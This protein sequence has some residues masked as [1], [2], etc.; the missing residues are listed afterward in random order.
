MD[1]NIPTAAAFCTGFGQHDTHKDTGEPY[2]KVTFSDIVAM[3]ENPPQTP[4][5]QAQWTIASRYCGWDARVFEVQRD[6]GEFG[7]IGLDFDGTAEQ[8]ANSAKEIGAALRAV[9]GEDATR[10][11]YSS[12]RATEAN[13]KSRVLLPLAD[14]IPGRDWSDT[15]EAIHQLLEEHGL[16]PDPALERAAQL[17]FLPNRG[18]YYRHSLKGV[19]PVDLTPDHPVIQRRE[20][21]RAARLEAERAAQEE[22]VWKAA[23]R[24]ARFHET[25]LE[26]PVDHFNK[27]HS[28]EGLLGRY[29]YAARG[30]GRD[31]RSPDSTSGSFALRDYGEYWVY[32]GSAMDDV[33]RKSA[34]GY[35]TGDAFDLFVYHEHG[36]D[37]KDAVRSYSKEAGLR[38]EP[39]AKPSI[40]ESKVVPPGD[41]RRAD[42]PRNGGFGRLESNA[43]F[44]ARLE[45]SD[46]LVDGICEKGMTYAITG[47]TGHGKSSLM[48]YLMLQVATGKPFANQEVEQGSVLF[49]AG[50]NPDN[51]RRQWRALCL[52]HGVD[53]YDLPV[54]WHDGAFRISQSLDALE[55]E[56]AKI[57]NLRLII[58][59][60]LQA[61]FE[62]ES[63]NDNVSMLNAAR[64]FRSLSRA[65][66]KPTVI[67]PAHPAGKKADKGN[68][69]PRGGGAFMNEID[70]NYTCWREDEIVTM[71]WQGKHRGSYFEPLDFAMPEKAFPELADTKGRQHPISVVTHLFDSDK[72][73]RA[74][75]AMRKE[76]DA[77]RAI[78][79]NNKISEAGLADALGAS[80]STAR[81]IKER[82][83][84]DGLVKKYARKLELTDEGL[85]V[86]SDAES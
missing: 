81:R 15:M 25:G 4:K 42:V 53:G 75:E 38:S 20:A 28:I 14:Y 79:A 30:N 61:F 23:E 52:A 43:A 45:P 34:A 46:Y 69:V 11:Y 8:P 66:G 36:G 57:P 3:A 64:N 31:W 48:L 68:L 6:R 55:A 74:Q 58:G 78:H 2:D 9:F 1:M 67:I 40:A 51:V 18:E 21:N 62:G 19:A 47:F 39:V 35:P 76:T 56:A 86:L 44:M 83:I 50:E 33:G 12:S 22:R 32:M 70:G 80:K 59:D 65:A 41:E 37:Y 24:R 49:L 60:T 84:K 54:F 10:L 72:R 73:R 26:S 63:D 77:L 13:P 16:R 71:H 5:A 85:E 7:L 27:A 17:I 29:G 82:L